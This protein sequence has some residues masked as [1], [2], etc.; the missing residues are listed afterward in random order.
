MKKICSFTGHRLN[1]FKFINENDINCITLY[2]I[3]NK[4]LAIYINIWYNFKLE[5]ILV[6]FVKRAK[7]QKEVRI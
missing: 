3:F 7:D 2:K 4:K 5:T 1:K 6:L